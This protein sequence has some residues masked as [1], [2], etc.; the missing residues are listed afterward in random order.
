M[1]DGMGRVCNM[2]GE[3]EN[4]YRILIGKLEGKRD[5][6]TDDSIILKCVLK[7]YCGSLW[8]DSSG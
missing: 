5:L 8:T 1:E 6:E 4:A 2:N 7:E 3:N